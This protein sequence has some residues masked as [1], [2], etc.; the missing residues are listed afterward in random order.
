MTTLLSSKFENL[1]IIDSFKQVVKSKKIEVCSKFLEK[2]N[3]L[4]ESHSK[5]TFSKVFHITKNED[6]LEA[7]LCLRCRVS[8]P[9]KKAISCLYKQHNA[10]HEIDYLNMMSYVLDDYGETYLRNSNNKKEK[11]KDKLFIWSNVIKIGKNKLRPFGVNILL[12]FNPELSNID[13]WTFHKVKSNFELKA[14]L[15][16]F[17]LNLK[18]IWSLISDQSSSRVKEAWRLYGDGSMNINEIDILHKSYVENYKKAKEEYRKTKKR[19]IGW[20]PDYKFLQSLIPKQEDTENLT[21]I[22]ETIHEFLS[23]AKGAP[24]NSRKLEDLRSDELF[25]KKIYVENSYDE[26]NSEKKLINL[27]QNSVR[28][29]SLK[30]LRDVLKS[31]KIKWK[32]NDNKRLA[33]E[34]YSDGLSQREIAKRCNHKQGWVSKLIKEK[35]ILERISLLAATELKEYVEFESLKKDPDKIDDL[36]MQLQDY[37]ISK[38]SDTDISI[39]KSILKEVLRK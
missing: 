20:H 14:Y 15:E 1:Y 10:I 29:A 18:G 32:E 37:L 8:D 30:I 13:T 39:L 17:G 36:I 11:S 26:I 35:I 2:E 3:L 38:Q 4:F 31:E 12:D 19:I 7:L 21:K 25:R 16:S 24:Q 23:A 9:I 6:S 34:L 5:K 33:W 22:A 28:K 27:I